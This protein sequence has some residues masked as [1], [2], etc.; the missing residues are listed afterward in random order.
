MDK[1]RLGWNPKIGDRVEGVAG[2]DAHGTGHF[3]VVVKRRRDGYLIQW[4]TGGR[5][6]SQ[7]YGLR[8]V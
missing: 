5:S 6:A 3:G 8:K 1:S 4:D 2:H 7:S